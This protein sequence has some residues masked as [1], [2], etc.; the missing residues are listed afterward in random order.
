[1]STQQQQNPLERFKD[2]YDAEQAVDMTV[3]GFGTKEIPNG[4]MEPSDVVIV[5]DSDADKVGI[6][7]IEE[8]SQTVESTELL[9]YD[10]SNGDAYE[11]LVFHGENASPPIQTKYADMVCD[12]FDV[13]RNEFIENVQ[14]LDENRRDFFPIVYEGDDYSAMISPVARD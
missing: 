5:F 12:V 3:D 4:Y 13:T 11:L 2:E 9:D 6:V 7:R 8:L 1:M 14:I 10:A